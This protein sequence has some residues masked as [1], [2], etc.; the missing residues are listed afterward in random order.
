M[1]FPNQFQ[2]GTIY[3]QIQ[4]QTYPIYFDTYMGNINKV[5]HE[6]FYLCVIA[7]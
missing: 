1:N 5:S 3:H 4:I 7:Y 2:E 6:I